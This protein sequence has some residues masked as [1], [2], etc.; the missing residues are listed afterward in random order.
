M[1]VV[2]DSTASNGIPR[3]PRLLR[4]EKSLS[5]QLVK[6]ADFQKD[7]RA[8]SNEYLTRSKLDRIIDIS[9]GALCFRQ[10]SYLIQFE[11]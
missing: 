5:A 9:G 1:K 11:Y 8:I 4:I 3:S 6:L 7:L 2:I 10:E